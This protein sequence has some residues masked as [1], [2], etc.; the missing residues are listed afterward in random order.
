VRECLRLFAG[1]MSEIEVLEGRDR[2]IAGLFVSVEATPS[3][4]H[5]SEALFS[6]DRLISARRPAVI[7]L[8]K[9]GRYRATTFAAS[10][11]ADPDQ[12]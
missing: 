4:S 7:H 11:R 5:S 3:S 10:D 12:T 2:R 1:E 8:P 9:E 6:A